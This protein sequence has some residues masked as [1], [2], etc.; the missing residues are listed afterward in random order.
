MTLRSL[1]LFGGIAAL[2]LYAGRSTSQRGA[3]LP[4]A[5]GPAAAD[6]DLPDD[7]LPLNSLNA[8]MPADMHADADHARPG[9]A[10]YARGA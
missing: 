6:G 5:D 1:V 10:D 9:F 2:A 7:D 3:A 4:Q 8:G